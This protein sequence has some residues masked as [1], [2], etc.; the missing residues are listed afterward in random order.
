MLPVISIFLVLFINTATTLFTPPLPPADV[1]LDLPEEYFNYEN[2]TIPPYIAN[3]PN[4]ASLDNTPDNNPVTN[5]ASTLGRVLFYDKNLSANN[6][7][8]CA[9]C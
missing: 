1:C 5:E 8:A 9:S 3:N 4:L 6:T 7:I 2:P